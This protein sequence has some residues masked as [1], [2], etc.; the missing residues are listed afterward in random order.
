MEEVYIGIGSNLGDRSKNIKQALEFLKDIDGIKLDKVSSFIE[1]K[2]ETGVGPDYLNGV[3]KIST[4]ISP[5]DLL[6]VLQ[7][8]ENRL[9][10]QRPFKAAPRTIDLDILLYGKRVVNEPGLVI[11]H[12]RIHQREFVLQPLAEL[13]NDCR[14]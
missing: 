5:R 10:R 9:G 11:P 7:G 2:P 12:P 1:S 4:E 8:I 13:R 3:A 6:E 14:N